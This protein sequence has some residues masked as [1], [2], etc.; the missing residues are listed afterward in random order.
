MLTRLGK[1]VEKRPWLIIGIVFMITIGF[2]SILPALEMETSTEDFMPDDE[3]VNANQRVSEYFGQS[4]EMLMVF[5]EKQN[6][7]NVVTPQ[8]LK[9][10]YYVSN[11]LQQIDEITSVMN[12]AGFVDTICSIEYSKSIENCSDIQIENAIQ[13][14]LHNEN[15]KILKILDEDD[16]NEQNPEGLKNSVNIKN[17]QILKNEKNYIFE[18]EV[19]NLAQ[20]DSELATASSNVSVTEWFISFDNE[21]NPFFPFKTGYRI[22]AQMTVFTEVEKPKWII[23]G[24]PLRNIRQF[25]KVTQSPRVN[26]S[27]TLDPYI[28][29]TSSAKET[30]FSISPESA[31]VYFDFLKNKITIEIPCDEL[32]QVGIAPQFGSFELPGKL[33]NFSVG[34][35]Y[36]QIPKIMYTLTK[37]FETL[38]NKIFTDLFTSG[39]FAGFSNMSEIDSNASS[40]ANSPFGFE[41]EWLDLDRAPDSGTS[42]NIFFIKPLFFEDL[43][44]T[45]LIFLS[46]DFKEDSGPSKTLMMIQLK[47][48]SDNM[49]F[50]DMGGGLGEISR[51]I[52]QKLFELDDEEP[53]VLMKITGSGIISNEMNEATEEAN[54]IIMPGIFVV[55][56]LIL[57]I[58]FKRLSYVV[59]PLASLGI[60]IIW[61]FGTMVLLG[62]SFN[63][64]MVA[65]VPLLMGL[66]VD[67]SVHLFHNYKAELKNGKKPGLAIIASIQDVGMAIFLAT[68]TTVIA[69]LS[70]LSAGIPPLRDF[71]VL[72]ALGIIYTLITALTFQTAVRF[73]LDRKKTTGLISKNS[74]KISLDRYMEKFSKIILK[75][76]KIIFAL[77]LFI[78][79]IMASGV[80]Q[81]ETTFDMND[82]LPEGNE[83]MELMIDIEEFFP[84]ASESQ[85]YILI[86]GNVASVETLNGISKTYENLKDDEFVT[87]TPSGDPKEKSILS[88]IRNAIRDN[89]SLSAAFNIDSYG[90]PEDDVDVVGIYDYLYDHD[91]YMMDVKSV[92]HREGNTY[93]ATVMRIYTSGSYSDVNSGNSNKQS[94]IL[95]ESLN[96]DMESYGE[97]DA[98]VTGSSSSIYT[99]MGSMTESQLLSTFISVLL[100]ALILMIVFRN[101]ILGLITI[102]PVGVS[103]IWIVGSIYFIGYSFNI[104]TVMVTSLNI[105]IGIAFGIHVTQRFRLTADRTGDVK[106]AVSNTVE[107]TG[108]ALFIAALTTA[109]GFGMLVLAPLPPEQQFGIITAMTIIYSYI[110]SIFVLPPVL[111]KW[112]LWRK[113]RKGFIISTRRTVEDL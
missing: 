11:E 62:L 83:A 3:I 106:K 47:I 96:D 81:V 89:S 92:L 66:G 18:I 42:S 84:S 90:I 52:E 28:S 53:Y 49:G 88:I 82:F 111:M 65:I 93:D 46:K 71:G 31:D 26:I 43:K 77:T 63:M 105:G 67:Y 6:E 40:S 85:E 21:I 13:D 58:M 7:Q 78:T 37:R 76:R 50:D 23:G 36:Y 79:V 104:M 68:L 110:T 29:I 103:I 41:S 34:T 51:E 33:T 9:E 100:A 64:M 32:G 15:T 14:L 80:S 22:S 74:N 45:A 19:Y 75:Q 91:E 57:L 5:V 20:V 108:G 56:C 60:S 95:Y 55:I 12:V 73:L 61:L 54:K 27:Y 72:C 17:C 99:I 112:G 101:L 44:S 25:K 8:A 70:F 4:G 30:E 94:E 38:L 1:T 2:G 87:M 10:A 109:A 102:I 97:A 86:E 35:R 24:G 113:K 39:D 16:P 69:F 59:L 48:I 107:H 98:I